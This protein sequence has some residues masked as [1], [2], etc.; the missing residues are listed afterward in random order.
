M[1]FPADA[2]AFY[3][4]LQEDNSREFWHANKRRYD[5]DV[6]GPLAEVTAL[7]ADEFGEA[8]LFR[9]YR[10]V[11]FS[12]NKAPFKTHQGAYVATGPACGFYVEVNGYE[13]HAGGGFYRA[14]SEGLARVRAAIADDASGPQLAAIVES[15]EDDAWLVTGDTIRTTPRGYPKT[16]PRLRLLRHKSLHAMR[17]VR[18]VGVE[19]F[20]AEVADAWRRIAPLVDWVSRRLE[21]G[22]AD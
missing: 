5:D 17:E 2:M 21:E 3:R 15:L 8:K 9:P 11:R 7:L 14:T 12:A 13:A 16:P 10:D 6:R 22:I 4:E 18:A 20:A 19:P 1:S